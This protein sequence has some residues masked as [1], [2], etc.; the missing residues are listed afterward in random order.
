[1]ASA[2]LLLDRGLPTANLNNDAGASRSNVQ[3]AFGSD[4]QGMWLAGDDFTLGGQGNYNV[5]TISV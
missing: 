3:W 4:A 2:A 1:M 5:T